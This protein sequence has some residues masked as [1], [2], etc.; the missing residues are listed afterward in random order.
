MLKNREKKLQ[1]LLKQ[2]LEKTF[3]NKLYLLLKTNISNILKVTSVN[4]FF[5][6]FKLCYNKS[7]FYFQIFYFNSNNLYNLKLYTTILNQLPVRLNL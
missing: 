6:Y 5:V 7:C 1:Q 4:I 3:T 2:S